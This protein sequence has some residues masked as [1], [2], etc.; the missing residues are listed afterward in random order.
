MGHPHRSLQRR[1]DETEIE[2]TVA[3]N[4]ENPAQRN[5]PFCGACETKAALHLTKLGAPHIDYAIGMNAAFGILAV[6]RAVER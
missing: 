5:L 2:Q 6:L 3:T 4:L 1:N